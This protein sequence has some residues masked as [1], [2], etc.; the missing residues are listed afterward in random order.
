MPG[1]EVPTST[2]RLPA[3]DAELV[4]RDAG[5]DEACSLTRPPALAATAVM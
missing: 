3:I 1:T 5:P 2:D 4:D